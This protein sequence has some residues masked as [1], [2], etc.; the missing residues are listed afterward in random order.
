MYS[1]TYRC[2][3]TCVYTCVYTRMYTCVS[4]CVRVCDVVVRVF[5]Y[6]CVGGF[7]FQFF[8]FACVFA[9]LLFS[10]PVGSQVRVFVMCVSIGRLL[11]MA[12]W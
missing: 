10:S 9:C 7:G 12:S 8:R 6:K 1:C 2:K 4:V 11:L 5:V 3:C